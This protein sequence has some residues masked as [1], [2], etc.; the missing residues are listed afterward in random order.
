M[1]LECYAEPY[2]EGRDEDGTYGE[3]IYLTQAQEREFDQ[4]HLCCCHG[5]HQGCG[6][7]RGKVYDA[8]FRAITGISLYG[9][10]TPVMLTNL[11]LPHLQGYLSELQA[12]SLPDD[13][14]ID[15]RS[16][17]TMVEDAWSYHTCTLGELK[18]LIKFINVCIENNLSLVGSY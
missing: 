8:V 2:I 17:N 3:R 1:G 14:I 12:A 11:V 18:E 10:C 4:V 13:H 9:R 15:A 7:F 6:T 16:L 5:D